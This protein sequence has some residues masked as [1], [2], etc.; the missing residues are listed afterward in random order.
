MTPTAFRHFRPVV[1]PYVPHAFFSAF[2]GPMEMRWAVEEKDSVDGWVTRSILDDS[3]ARLTQ[4]SAL[5]MCT[6]LEA[7][8]ISCMSAEERE[9][10]GISEAEYDAAIDTMMR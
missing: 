7:A 1:A 5:A 6:K 8:R 4:E 10:Q 9:A 2:I 3:G